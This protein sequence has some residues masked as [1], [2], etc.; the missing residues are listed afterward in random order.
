EAEAYQIGAE[1]P[2]ESRFL[3][4]ELRSF[5]LAVFRNFRHSPERQKTDA[6]N[7][8]AGIGDVF[9]AR[10]QAFIPVVVECFAA[11]PLA[12]MHIHLDRALL[13]VFLLL[14]F[15]FGFIV[16]VVEEDAFVFTE[17]VFTDDD[18]GAVVI[19]TFLFLRVRRNGDGWNVVEEAG[20]TEITF[21]W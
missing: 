13:L 6:G 2:R 10:Q 5:R 19:F 11:Q 17:I 8:N 21:V 20:Q 12:E 7:R 15:R 18:P 9:E 3:I 16:I 4:T 14:G 1:R